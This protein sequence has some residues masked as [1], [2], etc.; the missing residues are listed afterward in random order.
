ML[1][2]KKDVR[3]VYACHAWPAP[4]FSACPCG[5]H[6]YIAFACSNMALFVTP[7]DSPGEELETVLLA[8]NDEIAFYCDMIEEVAKDH[9]GEVDEVP[10]L[11][12]TLSVALERN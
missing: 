7:C 8:T 4:C 11:R 10:N 5:C 2:E 1:H 3:T 9:H 6:S 12:R